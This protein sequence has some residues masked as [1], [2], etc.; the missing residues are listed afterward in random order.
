MMSDI[1]TNVTA[2]VY[3]PKDNSTWT[4]ATLQNYDGTITWI[5][6]DN[7]G[8]NDSDCDADTPNSDSSDISWLLNMMD[9]L[10]DNYLWATATYNRLMELLS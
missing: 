7:N 5:P 4:N 1:F 8:D 6:Y 3:Y 2:D 10:E 9:N